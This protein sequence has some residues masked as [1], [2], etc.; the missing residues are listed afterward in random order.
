[1]PSSP[2]VPI[3]AVLI[4]SF[5]GPEAPDDVMPFLRN[6]TR[7]RNVPDE[8][9]AEVAEQYALFGGRS[10]I[11]DQCREL[12]AALTER[13][14]ATRHELPVYFGTRNWHPFVTDTVGRM[15]AEGVRHAAVF[16]TSAFG[17]Y[18]G[19]RQYREDLARARDEVGAGAPELTKLR[20]FY[21]HPGFI[22]PLVDNLAAGLERLSNHRMV[23]VLF[24]AHSIPLSMAAGCDYE[25]QLSVAAELILDRL[26]AAGGDRPAHDMVYQSRSGPPQVPWLEPDIND[27]LTALATTDDRPDGVVVVPLG[28]TSDHMEVLFDLD[29]QAAHT[30]AQLGLSFDRVPSV[31]T[32]PRYV[33]MI[34][35]LVD[36]IAAGATPVAIGSQGPWPFECPEWH[37]A[38]PQRPARRPA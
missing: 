22:D 7:G 12:A 13:L 32:D 31:G 30:A 2:D 23:R 14:A 36:E 37:C 9:L 24:S 8:R 21:N 28:F 18:S 1:M 26:E 15:A 10:P 3:D 20:L 38:P 17:S 29:T 33:D 19:C 6:V 5:G 25:D 11:N 35:A 4:L 16:V 27:H 34:V